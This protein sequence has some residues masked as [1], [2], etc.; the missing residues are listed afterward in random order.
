MSPLAYIHV[1]VELETVPSVLTAVCI[2]SAKMIFCINIAL[3]MQHLLHQLLMMETV[4]EMFDA[5]P[6]LM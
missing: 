3:C 6:T 2:W 5:K 4:Y 1:A